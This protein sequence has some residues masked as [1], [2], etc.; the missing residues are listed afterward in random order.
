[1][2]Y[3]PVKVTDLPGPVTVVASPILSE[4]AALPLAQ[5]MPSTD[6]PTISS[7]CITPEHLLD[8][9]PEEQKWSL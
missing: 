7:A 3:A 9:H 4:A 6:I 5:N 8:P 2:Q 1:M